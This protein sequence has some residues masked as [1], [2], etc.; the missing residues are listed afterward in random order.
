MLQRGFVI[1]LFIGASAAICRPVP[2]APDAPRVFLLDGKQLEASRQRIRQG[3]KGLAPALAALEREAQTALEVRPKSVMDKQAV[4]PS[5]D[6]HDYMSQ[7]PYFWPDPD[8]PDGLPYIRRDG[9][10]NPEIKKIPDDDNMA[11][12]SSDAETLGLAYYFTGDE[13]Y[14]AKAAELLRVWFLDPATRMN[15]NLRYAQA[16]PGVNTGRG[17][18]L[19]ESVRLTGAVD[20]AGLLAGSKAWTEADQQALEQWFSQFL[21]WMLESAPGRQEGAAKN[22]HGTYYDVQVASF[23]MFTGKRDLAESVL[24]EVGPKR[25][26]VQIEPDG[27]QPLE[28]ARTRSWGY[29]ISNLRGLMA[30]ARLGENVDVDLWRYETA[31]GRSIRKALDF[32]LPFAFGEKKWPYEQITGWSPQGAFALLRRA[33]VKYPDVERYQ[34]LASKLRDLGAENR[35]RLIY[36]EMAKKKSDGK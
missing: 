13:R 4:P 9:R 22:N 5:G 18:G 31:D 19:I 11:M 3:D 26:A 20:A 24:R 34:V 25:I 32:L 6:K 28:L 2:G 10:R 15:P 1:L 17:T 36:P 7:A 27:R 30:L 14:A 29:S 21:K 16:V 12:I 35:D 8:K 23:A 33:A